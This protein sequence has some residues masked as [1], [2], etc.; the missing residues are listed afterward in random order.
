MPGRRDDAYD[1]DRDGDRPRRRRRDEGD[2]PPPKKGGLGRLLLVL[3][4]VAGGGVLV[5]CGGCF[6]VVYFASPNHVE[7]LDGTRARSPQ[8]GTSSAAVNVRI[9]GRRGPG[10][11]GGDYYFMFK[12]GSRTSVH[13]TSL[14]VPFNGGEWKAVY[15]TPELAN[16][17][18]PVEFWVEQRDRDNVTKV[19]KVYTL[20]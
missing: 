6:A 3:L 13:P 15:A 11:M 10:M 8:G 9:G 4:L 20:P 12:A 14:R 7:L 1:D 17:P 19:S 2:D 18:G 16:E 5:C